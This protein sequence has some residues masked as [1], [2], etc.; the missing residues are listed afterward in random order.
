[1][2]ACADGNPY[3]TALQAL[4]RLSIGGHCA[5]TGTA[6]TG[7]GRCVLAAAHCRPVGVAAGALLELPQVLQ[8]SWANPQDVALCRMGFAPGVLLLLK[9]AACHG[10]R[11]A[12]A[13]ALRQFYVTPLPH[14]TGDVIVS[15]RDGGRWRARAWRHDAALLALAWLVD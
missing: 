9:Q 4:K 13:R 11:M 8:R 6:Y 1:V 2:L 7:P 5:Y 10:A 12:Q 15:M 14:T 3:R